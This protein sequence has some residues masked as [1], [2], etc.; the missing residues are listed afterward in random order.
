MVHNGTPEHSCT[1]LRDW[2]YR[3]YSVRWIRRRSPVVWP[4]RPQDLT[5]DFFHMGQYQGF[6]ISRYSGDCTNGLS[7]SSPYTEKKDILKNEY[8]D[9]LILK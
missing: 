1:P 9:I 8:V 7:C 6:D 3:A 5:L 2:L 4:L